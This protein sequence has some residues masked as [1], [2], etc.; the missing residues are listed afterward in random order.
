VKERGEFEE[1][2]PSSGEKQN[3][4]EEVKRTSDDGLNGGSENKR[5]PGVDGASKGVEDGKRSREEKKRS[6]KQRNKQQL[7]SPTNKREKGGEG[8]E[9]GEKRSREHRLLGSNSVSERT[10]DGSNAAKERTAKS[11][12]SPQFLGGHSVASMRRRRERGGCPATGEGLFPDVSTGCQEFY[13]CHHGHRMGQFSCPGGTLFSSQHE[14]C[15]WKGK[16]ACN[17]P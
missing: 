14:T 6:N 11:E 9:N 15:D 1:K 12:K 5:I 3:G 2:L 4:G 7:T 8:D 10:K 13:M 16:V 17:Q